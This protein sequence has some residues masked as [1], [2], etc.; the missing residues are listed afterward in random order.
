VV[1]CYEEWRRDENT[2]PTPEGAICLANSAVALT[3][4]SP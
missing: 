3:I 1:R 4:D 2:I